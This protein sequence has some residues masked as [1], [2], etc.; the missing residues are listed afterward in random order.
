M[1]AWR[2]VKKET[3]VNCFSKCGFN[4]PTLDLF[5]D[6]GADAEFVDLENYISRISPNSTVNSYLNQDED[7]VI[8]V[9]TEMKEEMRRKTICCLIEDD[10]E[11]EKQGEAE[12]KNR[13]TSSI[14]AA[15][16]IVVDLNS[17]CETLGDTNLDSES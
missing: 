5:I 2:K 4:E 9:N 3:I 13:K 15:L 7:V 6:D 1:E 16:S 8:S 10:V 14:Q 12:L 11:A 17:F